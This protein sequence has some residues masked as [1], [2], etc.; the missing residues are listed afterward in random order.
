MRRRTTLIVPS[1]RSCCVPNAWVSL[2]LAAH[3]TA[4]VGTGPSA[5]CRPRPAPGFQWQAGPAG[6]QLRVRKPIRQR[7]GRADQRRGAGVLRRRRTGRLT[8][9]ARTG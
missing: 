3:L 4:A 5:D 8:I 2:P 6:G 1:C 9:V 7:T